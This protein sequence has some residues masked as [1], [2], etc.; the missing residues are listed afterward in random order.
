MLWLCEQLNAL[1]HRSIL[2]ARSDGVLL[3]RARERKVDVVSC[4]PRFQ[5]DPFSAR[6]LRRSIRDDHIAIVHAHT[7]P[8]VAQGAL[9][10]RGTP[11]QLVVSRRVDIPLRQNLASRWKYGA[12]AHFIAISRAVEASLTTSGVSPDLVDVI[13]SGVDLSRRIVPAS[14]ERLAQLGVLPNVRLVVQVAQL[15]PP[16]DP[17][18]FVRAIDVARARVPN[19]F[20]LLAGGGPMLDAVRDEIAARNLGAHCAAPGHCTDADALLAAAEVCT[21]TS[22]QEGLGSVLLDALSLGRPVVATNVGGIPE[23]VPHNVCGLLAPV[24]DHE[25]LGAH[26]AAILQDT[27]LAARFSAAAA[28]RA[29]HFA[30]DETARRTAEVYQRLV[31][32]TSLPG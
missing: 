19:I 28:D 25:R 4:E 1:G 12:V 17:L 14:A 21:L 30:V 11:A 23:A 20:G 26:L 29:R 3:Q 7:G 15:V 16:K 27:S 22:Q 2:A 10:T 5:F 13:P 24:H 32:A 31:S 8:A 9:A 6:A 18:T